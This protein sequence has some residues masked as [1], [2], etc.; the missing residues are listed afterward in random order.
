MNKPSKEDWSA[1]YQA[2]IAFQRAA[3]WEWMSSED[4]FAIENPDDSETGYCSVLGSGGEEFGVGMFVGE[5]GYERCARLIAG[6]VDPEDPEESMMARSI[7][8]LF[9]DRDDL[10]KEERE[11]IRSLGLR[12]RGR[13][14]WPLFRSQRPGYVPW[15]LEKAEALFL[16]AAIQQAL[17]VADEIRAGELDLSE[18]E[19]KNLVLTRYYR[20]GRWH[21]ERRK[22]PTL[23]QRQEP[24]SKRIDAVKQAEL[25]LL[26]SRVSG[27]SGCWE[28]DIFALPVPIGQL[29]ERPHFPICFLAVEAKLGLILGTNLT[30]P[31]LNLSQKQDEVIHI[32]T[33]TNQLP[34]EI[35]VKSDKVREIVEP[36]TSILGIKLRV[37]S[38]PML[39]QV[40]ASL[41]E[42]VC[43]R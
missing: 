10:E 14:A 36:I 12:F 33:K 3:P 28:L 9:A 32:L 25:H 39:E 11:V 31:W 30:E 19:S 4:L 42:H 22:V 40:K 18:G 13:N 37:G 15:F 7:S 5:D 41:Y 34:G 43:G 21:E 23:S 38:L 16:T 6:E 35:R 24:N 8:L 27:L 17:V 1:L 2:A 20:S 26:R 29:P